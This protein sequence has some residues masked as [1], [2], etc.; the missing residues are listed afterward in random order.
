MVRGRF[1]ELNARFPSIYDSSTNIAYYQ[2]Y[3]QG[4]IN[5]YKKPVWVTE[6]CLPLP[7]RSFCLMTF[8]SGSLV[9]QVLL[10][11]SRSVV[12]L[13]AMLEIENLTSAVSRHSSRPWFLGSGTMQASSVLRTSATLRVSN[14][15]L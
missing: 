11:N 8:L 6:V 2:S 14:L 5:K 15:S 12:C 13:S 3:L 7:E 1:D 4:I 10:H 9:H